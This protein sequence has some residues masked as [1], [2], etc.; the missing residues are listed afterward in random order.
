MTLFAPPMNMSCQI[1]TTTRDRF[2]DWVYD[3]G[4]SVSCYFREINVQ[5]E[6]GAAKDNIHAES[7]DADAMIWFPA[8]TAVETGS[9]IFFDGFYYEVQRETKARRNFQSTVQF[10]KCDLKRTAVVS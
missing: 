2:G 10:I 5:R 3:S 8:G 7:N 1:V 9:L 4:A 6:A